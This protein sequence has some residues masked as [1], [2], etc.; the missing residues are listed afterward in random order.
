M[1]V[2]NP[3]AEFRNPKEIRMMNYRNPKPHHRKECREKMKLKSALY[4]SART[5]RSNGSEAVKKLFRRGVSP[6]FFRQHRLEKNAV[7]TPTPAV[8]DRRQRGR[9]SP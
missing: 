1:G 2:G 6:H 4:R 3:K 5:T 9:S 7:L 8:T